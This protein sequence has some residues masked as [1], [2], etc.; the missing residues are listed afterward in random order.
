MTGCFRLRQMGTDRLWS[1][2][3]WLLVQTP[4]GAARR[5][6]H[7]Q[8]WPRQVSACAVV[9]AI[10]LASKFFTAKRVRAVPL[11][12]ADGQLYA[13]TQENL[14]SGAYPLVRFLYVC[15]NKPPRQPLGGP[16]AEFLRY[17]L[18]REGQQVVADGGNIPLDAPTVA[19][20]RRAIR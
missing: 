13:P 16:A 9:G 19:E 14:R 2:A 6:G 7:C 10:G 15:V 8:A 3:Q 11:A 5:G 17:L 12:G 1:G 4:W 20:G 18:S